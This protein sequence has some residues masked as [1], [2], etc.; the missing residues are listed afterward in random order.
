MIWTDC[1]ALQNDLVSMRR[2]LHK[3]PELGLDLPKTRAY[4]ID[5]SS[6]RLMSQSYSKRSRSGNRDSPNTYSH[7]RAVDRCA[8]MQ[9]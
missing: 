9:C 7:P 3:I 1:K 4:V 8:L 5:R 2:E 6:F